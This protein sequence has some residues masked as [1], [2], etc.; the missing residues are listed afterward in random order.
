[1]DAAKRL[2]CWYIQPPGWILTELCWMKELQSPKAIYHRI[3]FLEHS[4]KW[5]N[6]RHGGQFSDCWGLRRGWGKE[7]VDVA[8]EG[9]EEGP[10]GHTM[11]CVWAALVSAPCCDVVLEFYKTLPLPETQG[12]LPS[13]GLHYIPLDNPINW[14]TNRKPADRGQGGLVSQRTILPSFIFFFFLIFTYVFDCAG[15]SWGTRDLW[16]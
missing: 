7:G 1:M 5:Q 14:E 16:L 13:P 8:T 3:P 10:W 2:K 12:I 9:Q 6:Y 4:W 11:S 15:L